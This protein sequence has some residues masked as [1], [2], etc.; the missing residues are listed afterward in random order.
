VPFEYR[1]A[2]RA[3]LLDGVYKRRAVRQLYHVPDH[4]DAG[5]AFPDDDRT[6]N[7]L[8]RTAEFLGRRETHHVYEH[9]KR[10]CISVPRGLKVNLPGAIAAFVAPEQY[11]LLD[12]LLRQPLSDREDAAVVA[13][14]VNNQATRVSQGSDG[15]KKA[16]VDGRQKGIE[17][18][19]ANVSVQSP[20]LELDEERGKENE[21]AEK[22][23]RAIDDSSAFFAILTKKAFKKQ[24]IRDWIHFEFG[25][26]GGK[27]KKNAQNV[28]R[29]F[30]IYVWKDIATDIPNLNPLKNIEAFRSVKINSKKSKNEMLKEMRDIA[31]R[32]AVTNL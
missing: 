8:H 29:Q 18:D 13:A 30:H 15:L 5:A 4:T 17:S 19:V 23:M 24:V 9:N 1:P 25:L 3:G 14:Q 27:H 10:A 7:S 28:V 2:C 12:E 21:I 26:A 31:N 32:I 6:V 16:L 11:P 22:I 20:G